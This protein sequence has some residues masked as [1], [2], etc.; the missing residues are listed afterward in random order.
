MK[1]ASPAV[2]DREGLSGSPSAGP[3][4]FVPWGEGHCQGRPEQRWEPLAPVPPSGCPTWQGSRLLDRDR[5]ALV[6]RAGAG[7]GYTEAWGTARPVRCSPAVGM[8]GAWGAVPPTSL[9]EHEDSPP[10]PRPL[11]T[12]PEVVESLRQVVS[13]HHRPPGCGAEGS[14]TVAPRSDPAMVSIPSVRLHP[15]GKPSSPPPREW[16]WIPARGPGKQG[17]L[18]PGLLGCFQ[19]LWCQPCLPESARG[20]SAARPFS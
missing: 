3:T 8:K 9:G 4:A 13:T 16:T 18:T 5:A 2:T 6:G 14:Q 7:P 15:H 19:C 1:I 20:C 10:G 12:K 11:P 17:L